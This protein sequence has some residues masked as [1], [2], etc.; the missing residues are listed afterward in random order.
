MGSTVN[1][2]ADRAFHLLIVAIA[3]AAIVGVAS[4]C[5]CVAWKGNKKRHVPATPNAQRNAVGYV[6]QNSLSSRSASGSL[7]SPVKAT[8]RP[9]TLPLAGST[10]R[11]NGHF[12][13]ADPTPVRR[14]A[15]HL[16]RSAAHEPQAYQPERIS[17]KRSLSA[18]SLQRRRRYGVHDGA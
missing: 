8:G 5:R 9:T 6:S 1:R 16:T 3:C 12:H 15:Q 13:S 18:E 2:S 17:G 4:L 14:R 10:R 11:S 7:R